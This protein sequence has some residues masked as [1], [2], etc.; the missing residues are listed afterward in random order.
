MKLLLINVLLFITLIISG[1][2]TTI[3][4]LYA[5]TDQGIGFRYDKQM[6]D[7][8]I[9]GA[10]HW[11][12]YWF[13]NGARINNHIKLSAGIVKYVPNMKPYAAE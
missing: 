5:P 11:G 13:K 1:Q 3:G 7:I 2:N 9:Y 4:F 8:G 6:T 12:S 10:A